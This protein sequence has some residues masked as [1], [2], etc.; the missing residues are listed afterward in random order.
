MAVLKNNEETGCCK[1]FDPE[2]WENKEIYFQDKLFLK[3][4]SFNLFH[5]PLNYGNVM[6]RSMKKIEKA[7]AKTNEQLMLSDES[8][9]WRSEIYIEVT[10]RIPK[11]EMVKIT[12]HFLSKVFEGSYSNSK[13][14]M[15]EMREFV[16]SKGKNMKKLYF[17]YTTCPSCAKAYG[18]NYTVLLAEI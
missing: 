7:G 11:S 14:W 2:P 8:S 6:K 4:H 12:G 16:K 15:E 5:I 18:K 10:K 13:K 3:N 1:R 9:P 17:F